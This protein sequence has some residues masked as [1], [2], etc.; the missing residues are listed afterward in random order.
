MRCDGNSWIRQVSSA[1]T[2][3]DPRG[4]LPV[5]L[6]GE[7]PYKDSNGVV[8]RATWVLTCKQNPKSYP[9]QFRY[10]DETLDHELIVDGKTYF[11][12]VGD[13]DENTV[14]LQTDL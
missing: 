8:E 9:L 13:W 14:S 7:S 10:R 12:P 6:K 2:S 11:S 5:V 1:T 3:V 4:R